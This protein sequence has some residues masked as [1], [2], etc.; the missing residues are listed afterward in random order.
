MCFRLDKFTTSSLVPTWSL[1][2]DSYCSSTL[3]GPVY[4]GDRGGRP[5]LSTGTKRN[6]QVARAEGN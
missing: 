4:G 1:K 6:R 3:K 5:D 2:E